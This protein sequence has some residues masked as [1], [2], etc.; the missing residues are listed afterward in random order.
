MEY[1]RETALLLA[2]ETGHLMHRKKL[3]FDPAFEQAFG[4]LNLDPELRQAAKIGVGRIFNSWKKKK[5]G[6]YSFLPGLKK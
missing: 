4:T 5:E 2:T 6:Q 3:D 1:S